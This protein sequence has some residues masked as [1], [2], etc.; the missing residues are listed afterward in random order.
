[1]EDPWTCKTSCLTVWSL[2]RAGQDHSDPSSR[3]AVSNCLLLPSRT[4]ELPLRWHEVGWSRKGVVDGV[5]IIM[6]VL[7]TAG[8]VSCKMVKWI[9]LQTV[10]GFLRVQASG[11]CVLQHFQHRLFSVIHWVFWI[12]DSLVNSGQLLRKCSL[13]LQKGQNGNYLGFFSFLGWL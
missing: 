7:S 9:S 8:M 6:Q 11:A 4:T 3:I 10:Q 5:L 12:V 2:R 13:L 1:M